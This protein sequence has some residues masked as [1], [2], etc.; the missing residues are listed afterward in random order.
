MPYFPKPSSAF[1]SFW[2]PFY[3]S[4]RQ[5]KPTIT[6][7]RCRS[8][9]A[10]L[11]HSPF[12]QLKPLSSSIADSANIVDAACRPRSRVIADSG[13]VADTSSH[14]QG[15]GSIKLST[16]NYPFS[17]QANTHSITRC[18]SDQNPIFFTCTLQK[19]SLCSEKQFLHNVKSTQKDTDDGKPRFFR[20]D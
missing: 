12:K 5:N 13:L 9:L 15:L 2:A 14:A 17:L 4:T 7:T 6:S 19:S 18:W 16:T 11:Q 3:A 20:Q 10:R 1:D 8:P